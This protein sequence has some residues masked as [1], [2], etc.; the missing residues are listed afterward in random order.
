MAEVFQCGGQQLGLELER[1]E[2][3]RRDLPELEADGGVH[4]KLHAAEYFAIVPELRPRHGARRARHVHRGWGAVK[5][6]AVW[7]LARRVREHLRFPL[8]HAS[9]S[10]PRKRGKA[11]HATHVQPG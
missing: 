9:P 2:Q 1:A 8:W 10:T 6:A 11:K 4:L 3:L 7:E 5:S